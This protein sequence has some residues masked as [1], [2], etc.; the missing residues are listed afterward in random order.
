MKELGSTEELKK[1]L[2]SSKSIAIF[3]YMTTCG[4]CQ[5][6]HDPWAALAKEMPTVQFAKVNS[7]QKSISFQDSILGV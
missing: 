5:A 7:E 4:H 1:E 6:M 2:K 3:M